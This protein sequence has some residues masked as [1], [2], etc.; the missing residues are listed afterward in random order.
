M[1][2]NVRKERGK[3]CVYKKDGGRKVGCTK[4]TKEAKK[5]YLAALHAAEDEESFDSEASKILERYNREEIN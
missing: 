1:P 3:Y 4:G 2:Y 5:K